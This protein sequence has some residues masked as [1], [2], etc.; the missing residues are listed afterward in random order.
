MELG[1]DKRGAAA[2]A[3]RFPGDWLK[4]ALHLPDPALGSSVRVPAL[5]VET[6]QEN[7]EP[8]WGPRREA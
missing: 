6:Q 5:G 8:H 1:G 4:D 7:Q 3:A 2:E